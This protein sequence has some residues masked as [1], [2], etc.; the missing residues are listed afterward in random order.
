M[1]PYQ[2]RS[3]TSGVDEFKNRPDFIIVRFRGGDLYVYAAERVGRDHVDEMKP[4]A[5]TG[6]G[7]STYVNE[8]P[9]G[10]EGLCQVRPER[11]W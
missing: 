8:H 5:V 10:A 4:L 6:P 11:P 9:E 3:G 2:D 7:L 1:Q